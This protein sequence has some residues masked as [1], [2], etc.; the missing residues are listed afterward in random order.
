MPRRAEF[1][2]PKAKE[3]GCKGSGNGDL[4][5]LGV[6]VLKLLPCNGRWMGKLATSASELGLR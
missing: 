4:C 1:Y 3:D 5:K 2:K 6:C